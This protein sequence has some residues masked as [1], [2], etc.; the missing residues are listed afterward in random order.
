M[1]VALDNDD[2]LLL[3]VMA[4]KDGNLSR[5]NYITGSSNK[6][7]DVQDYHQQGNC[8]WCSICLSRIGIGN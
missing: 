4:R 5:P 1:F 7:P 3:D 2:V 6:F 8:S